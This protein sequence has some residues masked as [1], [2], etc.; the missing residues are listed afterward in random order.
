[1]P[2][3]YNGIGTHYYGKRNVQT[4]PATCPHCQRTVNLISYDTRLWFVVFFI[5]VIPIGRKRIIDR[6]TACSRHYVM[7][8]DKW[9]TAKQLETS[10]ALEKFR[11]NPTPE[12]A[13]EAHRQFLNFQ[14]IAE[15]AELQK[16]MSE[17][18]AD[19]ARVQAYLAAAL[20]HLGKLSEAGPF[21]ARA[22]ALRPDLPE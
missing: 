7:D 12:A 6:C 15:A 4:R 20:T 18:F 19:N 22:L 8:A 2:T 10:G 5:P 11:S 13:I 3:T 9:E 21:F 1:M 14:Q 17:K 16:T